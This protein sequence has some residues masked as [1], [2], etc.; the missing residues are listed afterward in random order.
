MRV[1]AVRTRRTPFYGDAGDREILE[2]SFKLV[3]VDEMT[4]VPPAAL[5][6]APVIIDGAEASSRREPH[7]DYREKGAE[8]PLGFM[9]HQG[10]NRKQRLAAAATWAPPKLPEGEQPPTR[11]ALHEQRQKH[12]RGTLDPELRRVQRRKA[13]T[14]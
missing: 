12:R 1:A 3:S 4:D 5:A 2:P 11:R 8:I 9:P 7:P 10:E 14:K 13:Q 6:E